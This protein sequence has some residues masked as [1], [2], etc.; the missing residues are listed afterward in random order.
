MRARHGCRLGF[1]R[2][3][4]AGLALGAFALPATAAAEPLKPDLVADPPGLAHDVNTL[5]DRYTAPGQRYLR[6][7]GWIHNA[8]PGCLQLIGSDN[9][10][11][12]LTSVVQRLYEPGACETYGA[13]T[14]VPLGAGAVMRYETND[15]HTH[16]H[17]M[18]AARYSL[19][20][21]AMTRE[22]GPASKVGFCLLD[23]EN[24][25]HLVTFQAFPEDWSH[26]CNA[27]APTASTAQMG[28]SPG[29]RDIY[30]YY[31]KLQWVDITDVAPGVYRVAAQMDPDNRIIEQN[32][33]NPLAFSVPIAIPGYRAREAT[34]RVKGLGSSSVP[35]TATPFGNP[36]GTLQFAIAGSPKHGKLSKRPGSL[37]TDDSVTYRPRLGFHGR[38]SFTFTARNG[39][40]PV[41]PPAATVTLRVPLVRLLSRLGL[42]HAGSAL[43]VRTVPRVSGTLSVQLKRKGKR[44]DSCRSRARKGR[45][46][47]CRLSLPS[48]TRGLTVSASLRV[49]G[50]SV[51]TTQARVR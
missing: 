20:D 46:A 36:G 42:T 34:R 18:A 1:G 24:V 25:D 44:L 12:V 6:F 40:F 10:N 30:Q 41:N 16:F 38:D 19:W 2:A 37:F 45:A 9:Q 47:G 29:W 28:L 11:G 17:F 4:A 50:R 13:H 8:G 5:I 21:E 51:Y 31:L 32:E 39:P 22:V 27:G 15:S 14:D 7:D 35:L 48:A 26:H 49:K 43:S 33:T 23:S 3:V